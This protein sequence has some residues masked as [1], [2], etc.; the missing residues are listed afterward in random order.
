MLQLK[1][2]KFHI[3]LYH[4]HWPVWQITKKLWFTT[5][6]YWPPI[7]QDLDFN[8]FTKTYLVLLHACYLP[9]E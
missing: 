5:P 8:M 4:S 1:I 6:S 7:I 2:A 9:T 3:Y